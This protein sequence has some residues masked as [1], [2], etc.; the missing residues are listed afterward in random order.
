MEEAMKRATEESN[1]FLQGMTDG[2]YTLEGHPSTFKVEAGKIY[3]IWTGKEG[4]KSY[5]KTFET[6]LEVKR[7]QKLMRGE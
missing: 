5:S 4:S 6:F 7:L 2:T 3:E 1:K